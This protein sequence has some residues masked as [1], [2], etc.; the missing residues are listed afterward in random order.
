MPCPPV[1]KR[2]QLNR[3]LTCAEY[4]SNLDAVLNRCNHTGTQSA[5]TIYDLKETVEN[6][7]FIK[8]LQECCET[9]TDELDQLKED[10]FGEGELSAI[11]NNLRNELIEM[12]NQVITDL[13]TL[14][15]DLTA[16]TVRVSNLEQALGTISDSI[17]SLSSSVTA[18][19]N[20]VASKAP[21]NSPTFT[22]SPKAPTPAVGSSDTSIATTA[23]VRLQVPAGL[24]L[25]YAGASAPSG[26]LMCQGQA[27][28]RSTYAAL[29]TVIGTTYG[30]GDGSTTFQ[31][32]NL[33]DRVPVGAGSS[34]HL[35]GI[36]GAAAVSIGVAN[37]PSHDHPTIDGGH[38]H[39]FTV[40]PHRHR[41]KG[42]NVNQDPVG[43][44]P[45]RF[46]FIR[47]NGAAD[48]LST[49]DDFDDE[50][51]YSQGV[52]STGMTNA[53]YS[54]VQVGSTG[55]NQP[56]SVMQPYMVLHYIIKH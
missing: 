22:G 25:P 56:I 23:F 54:G 12:I 37:L 20:Q 26:Y 10:L 3:E 33:Q 51:S 36:G 27:V 5:K 46:G 18:L 13:E 35:A 31:L 55:G 17:T 42:V 9:L 2:S 52:P 19:A 4:D 1:I 28:S 43:G 50:V 48:F 29:F 16:L 40:P 38:A 44:A 53:A 8:A 21:L 14:E 34:F 24:V 32:P 45:V 30:V 41:V 15:E 6:Y 11:I 7:D 49:L 47:V 39:Q